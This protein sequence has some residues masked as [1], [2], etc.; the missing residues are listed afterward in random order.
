MFFESP[1]AVLEDVLITDFAPKSLGLE[2]TYGLNRV[3]IMS[4]V[5]IAENEVGTRRRLVRFLEGQHLEVESVADGQALLDSITRLT[6]D[7]VLLDIAMP[8]MDGLSVIER[9]RQRG[10]DIRVLMMADQGAGLTAISDALEQGASDYI[11]KPVEKNEL[12]VRVQRALAGG[13]R[14]HAALD[15]PLAELHD[16]DTGRIDAKRVAEFLAIPLTRLAIAIGANYPTVHKT[17]AA[18]GL[19]NSLRPI[20]RAI[21]LVSELTRTPA[22]A[23]A[24]L[25]NPHPDLG[26]R[27][28]PMEAILKG[29]ADALVTLLENALAGIPS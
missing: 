20:K 5:V 24:W 14:A 2:Y 6:P 8:E 29:K 28:T 1:S 26:R 17:P 3:D 10:D 22:D 12:L 25:N 27:R 11:A 13:R 15:V 9:L 4:R 19:Q 21:E 16:P 23:R 18:P 7:L